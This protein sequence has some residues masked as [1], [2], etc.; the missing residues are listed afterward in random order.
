MSAN[1]ETARGARVG[2]VVDMLSWIDARRT[3]FSVYEFAEAME[4]DRRRAWDWLDALASRGL[5]DVKSGRFGGRAQKT[6]W[7]SK[8]RFRVN[9]ASRET[10]A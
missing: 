2:F 5:L 6:Y 10:A 1:S 8:L 9:G 3:P 7:T 4:V